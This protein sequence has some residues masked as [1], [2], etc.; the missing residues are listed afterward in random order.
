MKESIQ[1][2]SQKIYFILKYSARKNLRITVTPEME[3]I[4]NAPSGTAIERIREKVKHKVPW[5]I[6][7]QS[8]FISFMP[9]MP[10]R[11]YVGGESHLYMGRHYLLKV[12]TG[13]KVVNLIT[14]YFECGWG[15]NSSINFPVGKYC[16]ARYL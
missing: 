15:D 1:F 3:V 4:V 8:Y 13:R 11:R 14:P 16:F 12:K 10:P 9:I 7:Q 6:K 5:I 2:G